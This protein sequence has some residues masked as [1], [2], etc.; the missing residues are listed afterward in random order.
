MSRDISPKYIEGSELGGYVRRG[1]D[2]ID[3]RTRTEFSQQSY[4]GSLNLPFK[5]NQKKLEQWVDNAMSSKGVTGVILISENGNESDVREAAKVL[6]GLSCPSGIVRGG[7]NAL[8]GDGYS[9]DA[10]GNGK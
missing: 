7:F 4:I 10:S 2:V 9:S 5:G 8:V 1:W 6:A 3:I